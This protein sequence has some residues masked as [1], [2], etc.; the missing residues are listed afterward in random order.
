MY[1]FEELHHRDIPGMITSFG[2]SVTY[3]NDIGTLT[4]KAVIDNDVELMPSDFSSQ[5]PEIGTV[6]SILS[7]SVSKSKIGDTITH[8]DTVYIV[9]SVMQDD[10][11]VRRLAVTKR[12]PD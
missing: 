11:F 3:E 12:I 7:S 5:I 6:I 9:Q 8:G 4:M 10:R 1:S 2:V